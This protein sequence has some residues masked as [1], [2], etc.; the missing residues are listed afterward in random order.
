MSS[1]TIKILAVGDVVGPGGTAHLEAKLWN[2]RRNLGVSFVVANGENAAVGNGIDEDSAARLLRCGCDVLTSGNHV[3]QNRS[4]YRRLDDADGIIRPANLPPECPGEGAMIADAAGY[5]VLVLNIMG[6]VY[7]DPLNSPFET[8]TKLFRQYEGSYDFAVLD[9]HGEATSEK[10][11]V[12]RWLDAQ[13]KLRCAAVFGTHTHVQTA[14]T[15]ILPGGTGFITDL[16]MTG[17]VNSILGV[18]N[19]IIIERMRTKMPARF[20]LADGECELHGALFE[21]DPGTAKTVS[22]CGITA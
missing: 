3:L 5:R 19:E 4:I 2:L 17:P 22:V 9:I 21:I 10:A 18:K 8:L 14:D 20:E 7:M 1:N 12:A 11:A 15:R 13:P 6:V 16:G